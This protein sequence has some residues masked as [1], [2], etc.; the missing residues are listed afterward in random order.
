[1]RKT[2]PSRKNH[3]FTGLTVMAVL[4]AAF[5]FISGPLYLSLG[6][7]GRIKGTESI[8]TAGTYTGVSHGYSGEV[9]V[10]L[11]V[12]NKDIETLSAKGPGETPDIGGQA[13]RVLSS[14]TLKQ[15]TA[16]VDAVAGATYTSHAFKEAANQALSKAK[17]EAPTPKENAEAISVEDFSPKEGS[18][19][20]TAENFD[21]N[22]FKDQVSLTVKNGAVTA[23]TWDCISKDGA[24][25]SML[26]ADGKY[27]MSETGAPWYK[28]AKAVADYVISHQGTENLA[29]ADGYANDTIASVSINISPFLNGL[30][31]CLEQA[32][33]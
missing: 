11:T 26:S 29:T 5:I 7:I 23:C 21:D 30:K 33:E 14:R 31:A 12:S 9:T 2:N 32:A 3:S 15:Q 10:I 1:M 6:R 22:G 19:T 24:T 25:K 28:Q 4:S 20:W 27:V 17:G 18:Y 8:Y 13:L 16:E